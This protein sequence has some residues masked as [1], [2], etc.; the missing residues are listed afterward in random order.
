MPGE[1]DSKD[2][3]TEDVIL[4]AVATWKPLKRCFESHHK[5]VYALD[6]RM[7]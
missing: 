3:G 6:F 1:S 5:E 4:F 2:C 7:A